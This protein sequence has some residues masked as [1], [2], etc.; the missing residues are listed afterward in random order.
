MRR[1][2]LFFC[3][4]MMFLTAGCST[5]A[6]KALPDDIRASYS[7]IQEFTTRT[8]ITVE[9]ADRTAEYQIDWV[10][11]H[12]ISTMT[13][14]E[15]EEIAGITA[16][17]ND[18]GLHFLYKDAVLTVEPGGTVL[19]PL[20]ALPE[21]FFGWVGGEVQ[22]YTRETR[23]GVETLA[24]SYAMERG[25]RPYCQRVWFDAARLTPLEAEF[26]QNGVLTLRCTFLTFQA[27]PMPTFD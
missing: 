27:S 22:D 13:V 6:K 5:G 15:P 11:Q 23:N 3:A 20:E 19:S 24:V 1:S 12:G 4:L 2:L 8:A 10:Y 16:R 14:V 9:T 25:G 7:A 18:Q 26:Y 17:T 21:L